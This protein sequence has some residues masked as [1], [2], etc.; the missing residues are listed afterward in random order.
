M[1]V[2]H[3]RQKTCSRKDTVGPV[4]APPGWSLLSGEHSNGPEHHARGRCSL[5]A[6]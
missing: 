3:L 4:R 2:S 6:G 5:A 1:M